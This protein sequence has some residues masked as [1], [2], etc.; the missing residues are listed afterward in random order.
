VEEEDRQILFVVQ[1]VSKTEETS[2]Q[3]ET[4]RKGSRRIYPKG[5][6]CSS[7]VDSSLCQS[8]FEHMDTSSTLFSLSFFFS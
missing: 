5:Y 6:T 1:K 7:A 2:K 3:E 8:K 4:G